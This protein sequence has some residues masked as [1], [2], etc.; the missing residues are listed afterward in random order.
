MVAL[1]GSRP[2]ER[3]LPYAT[4]VAAA[5]DSEIVLTHVPSDLSGGGEALEG[6]LDMV[7]A[8]LAKAEVQVS[9]LIG[10]R[11]AAVSL[12]ELARDENADAI[13][14]ATHGR[15]GFERVVIGSVASAVIRSAQVPVLL[16]PIVE[17]RTG[18]PETVEQ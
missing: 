8:Q 6:Y 7:A 9:T 17:S 1:D 10:G 11:D 2:A 4:A 5:T 12:P 13:F 15:G 3:V 14:L 16:V 18:R